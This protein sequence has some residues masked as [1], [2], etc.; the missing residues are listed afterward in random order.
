MIVSRN[1]NFLFILASV[2]KKVKELKRPKV[3]ELQ[4]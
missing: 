2:E 4:S 3:E 1:N